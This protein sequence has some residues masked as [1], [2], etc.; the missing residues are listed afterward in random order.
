MSA[1]IVQQP[2]ELNLTG[3]LRLKIKNCKAGR[4]NNSPD[5]SRLEQDRGGVIIAHHG[6]AVDVLLTGGER[7]MVRVKRRSGHVVG[8]D[9]VIRGEVLERLPRRTELRRRDATGG[10]HLVG[11]NL[12][13]LGVVASPSPL[14][15]A[16]FIDRAIVAAR[17]ANLRPFVVVNKCDL[18]GAEGFV[19]ALRGTYFETVSVFPLSAVTGAGLTVLREFLGEGHRGAF[20]GT[21]GVGKSSLL[22]ALCPEIDLRVGALNNYNGKGR[23]TTTVSTLHALS[24]GGELVDTPGFQDFGIVDI[25]VQDYANHFPGFEK[26]REVRCRFRD[27]RHRSEPGC[28]VVELVARGEVAEERYATYLDILSEVEAAEGESRQG[29]WKN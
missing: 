8:D 1:V 2:F 15:P 13:V 26:T 23:H 17:A 3:V 19:E 20:V 5:S 21:T 28:A 29:S 6:V 24:S 27:C 14:P 9:V 11:A 10:I 7:C 16:G 4:S 12:D 18:D 25:S 22:N